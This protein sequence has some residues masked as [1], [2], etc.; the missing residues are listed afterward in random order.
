MNPFVRVNIPN[1]WVNLHYGFN[2]LM[3]PLLIS[4]PATFMAL[5]T[6]LFSLIFKVTPL[7][8]VNIALIR[9]ST[10]FTSETVPLMMGLLVVLEI[11][12]LALV[13]SGTHAGD[14]LQAL[15]QLVLCEPVHVISTLP[16]DKVN[17]Q[18]ITWFKVALVLVAF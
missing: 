4:F 10:L 6:A 12:A 3:I 14:Q 9:I 13:R 2:I 11:M 18:F 15:F 17:A 8:I 5:F 16:G 7:F 1:K